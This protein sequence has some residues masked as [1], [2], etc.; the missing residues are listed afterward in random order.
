MND[1]P[2]MSEDLPA[3]VTLFGVTSG[4]EVCTFPQVDLGILEGS[5]EVTA[6]E[7][8]LKAE[9]DTYLI[10]R[11]ASGGK[12]FTWVGVYRKAFETG[13]PRP[14]NYY[15]AGLWLL[16]R[17][18]RPAGAEILAVLSCVSEQLQQHAVK[19]GQLIRRLADIRHAITL[20]PVREDLYRIRD[21][22]QPSAQPSEL[23]AL[24]EAWGYIDATQ[25]A[26]EGPGLNWL[27]DWA[28]DD[29]AL[30]GEFSRVI[31]AVDPGAFASGTRCSPPLT[32]RELRQG[33]GPR[34]TELRRKQSVP[35]ET[36]KPAGSARLHTY[37]VLAENNLKESRDAEERARVN[38]AY[39]QEGSF[40]K[41][42]ADVLNA[43]KESFF[44][45]ALAAQTVREAGKPN[46]KGRGRS[47]DG[48]G[49]Y[50]NI[51]WQSIATVASCFLLITICIVLLV[52][53]GSLRDIEGSLRTLAR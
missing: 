20:D 36:T 26:I 8:T 53:N 52:I 11:R 22:L 47:E 37:E 14:G 40:S 34:Q 12:V 1:T 16:K 38:I 28:L 31:I 7:V 50:G 30:F 46:S 42:D 33:K 4:L 6:N 51:S 27:L 43:G 41:P 9:R 23:D 39:W 35:C 25:M 48:S 18:V 21:A 32:P 19:N 17:P 5:I 44:E 49:P 29:G 3:V 2:Q 45:H 24:E 13:A 15:G 10:H